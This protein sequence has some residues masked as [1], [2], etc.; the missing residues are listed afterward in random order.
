[1]IALT[2][3]ILMQTLAGATGT[4]GQSAPAVATPTEALALQKAGANNALDSRWVSV[5]EQAMQENGGAGDATQG[6][7]AWGKDGF[8]RFLN[9]TIPPELS[10]RYAQISLMSGIEIEKLKICNQYDEGDIPGKTEFADKFEAAYAQFVQNPQTG[11]KVDGGGVIYTITQNAE[12]GVS[13]FR[14]KKPNGFMRFLNSVTKWAKPVLE[15][16]GWAIP[17]LQIVTRPLQFL[18]SGAQNIMNSRYVSS[19]EKE[20][21]QASG[22]PQ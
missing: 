22:M 12:G 13:F 5:V 19:V 2:R 3:Q 10:K 9:P 16:V 20:A 8:T 17:P 14:H 21:A 18:M 4:A 1:M 11:F 7:L 15:A 6:F